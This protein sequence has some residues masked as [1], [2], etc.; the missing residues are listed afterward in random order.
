MPTSAASDPRGRCDRLLLDRHGSRLLPFTHHV[1]VRY[2]E[3]D[4]QDVVFNAHYLTY[5]DDAMTRFVDALGYE[6]KETFT[7]GG[8]FD[9]MLVRSVIDW[10]GSAGFDDVVDIAVTPTR[11]GTSSFDV[12]FT[13]TVDG[14]TAAV[15]VT[16]YVSVV[17]GEAR[18]CPIPAGV[19]ADL[20][21][22]M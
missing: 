11:L 17:P 12:T 5:F 3:V 20:E 4:A 2:A 18:A 15:G 10:Q 22:H 1:R 13:A 16:T 6:P 8:A 7:E 19:R 9:V 14:V 21:S